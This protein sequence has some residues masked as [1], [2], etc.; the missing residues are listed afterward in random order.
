MVTH[1]TSN[2][3]NKVISNEVIKNS[4]SDMLYRGN[5]F[6][7]DEVVHITGVTGV[8]NLNVF[9]VTGTVRVLNQWAEIT[10]ITT[11]TNM[12][13]VYAD[14]YD[15]TNTADLTKT[16]GSTLSGAAVGTFF[17][18]DK[19]A[20]ET[21]TVC[22]ANEVRIAEATSK[23][24]AP[25]FVTQKNGADTFIRFNFTTTDN[26]IDFKMR[27]VFQ[28]QPIDGGNLTLA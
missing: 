21:Y 7:F 11:L 19:A 18:K 15:G 24:A 25:F 14:A 16:P 27:V 20:T 12:T 9:K 17:T 3:L 4:A 22:L 28:Y 13:D 5:G 2:P 1:N 8:V 6:V 23:Q 10:E 26:P